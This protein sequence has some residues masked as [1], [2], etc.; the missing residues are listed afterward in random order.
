M[1]G[2]VDVEKF[3][4]WSNTCHWYLKQSE[5]KPKEIVRYVTDGMLEPRFVKWYHASQK[6][7]NALSLDEYLTKFV[8]YA[9]PCK[10]EQGQENKP[11]ANWEIELEN[12]NALLTNTKSSCALSNI[13]LQAQLEANMSLDLQAKLD[14]TN[15]ITTVFTDWV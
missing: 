5:K 10:W 1:P 3:Q 14:N 11:F 7:I 6:H 15:L 12:L 9:L 2:W 13:A 4:E 8:K